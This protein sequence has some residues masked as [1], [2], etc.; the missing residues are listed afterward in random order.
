M[1]KPEGK[2]P[3]KHKEQGG[4][5][6]RVNV[7]VEMEYCHQQIVKKMINAGAVEGVE[8]WRFQYTFVVV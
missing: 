8:N 7:K 6:W 2:E 1:R 3:A 4:E 5:G